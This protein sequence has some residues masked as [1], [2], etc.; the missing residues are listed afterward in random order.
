MLDIAPLRA[1]AKAIAIGDP[2]MMLPWSDSP[3][4]RSMTACVHRSTSVDLADL[5]LGNDDANVSATVN[6][7]SPIDSTNAMFSDASRDASR[8]RPCSTC[9]TV[10]PAIPIANDVLSSAAV[11]SSRSSSNRAEMSGW[12]R[13]NVLPHISVRG[14]MRFAMRSGASAGSASAT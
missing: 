11:H 3:S 10:M 12:N 2:K 6:A 5:I 14:A 13:R 8:T 7:G 4:A 9:S 1:I